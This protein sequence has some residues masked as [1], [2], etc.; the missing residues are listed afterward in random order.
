MLYNKCK[1]F[2]NINQGGLLMKN[3]KL[4]A[5]VSA[6]ILASTMFAGCGAK[7]TT[8]ASGDAAAPA[9]TTAKKIV[10][11]FA[12]IGAESGWRDA[13]TN[14]VKDIPNNNK[15]IELKFSDGQ[16]KQENQIKAIRSFIAQKVDV[17]AL[18]PVVESG[19]DTVLKE[20]KDAKIPVVLMDRTIKVAD[21]TLFTTFIGS[22]F[23]L[24][25]KNAAKFLTDKYGK[26]GK[27]NIVELQGTVGSSA[28]VDRMAGFKEGI[29]DFPGLKIIKS[30][31]G[32][33]TRAKGKEVM[34]AF[35]KSDGKNI[36]VLYAHNDDMAMGAIQAIEE[37]GLKPGKD[38]IIVS[39]DGIKDAFTAMSQGKTNCI[40]ECN[41]LLGPQLAL[42]AKDLVAGKTVDKWIKSEEGVFAGAEAATKALPDRKY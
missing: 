2:N 23:P 13:E 42:V 7:K 32:D 6:L 14:S 22:D 16:Q 18:A 35:L 36:Q 26:D 11:G 19:W 12:Q 37:Y 41:P 3:K 34:E 17:I 24:E 33:F 21:E 38:I 39:I 20:A 29:K 4:I 5:F 10:I 25:G 30:Q 31:T 27:V 8:P 15:D 28:Q 1:R 9:A 40:V